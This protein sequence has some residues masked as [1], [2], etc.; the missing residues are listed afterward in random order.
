M[1]A[2]DNQVLAGR[3]V[4]VLTS[5]ERE[6]YQ[7]VISAM[8]SDNPKQELS[9]FDA[10]LP[11]TVINSVFDD[12][13]EEHPLL[14]KIRFA[15]AAALIKWLYSTMDDRFLAWW[16]PLCGRLK[17]SLR[18]NS[19]TSISNRPNCRL[20]CLLQGYVGSWPRMA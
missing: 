18:P 4:R 13:T 10:V 20:L 19:I 6:F 1:Q 7:K 3:G 5:N 2:S 11:E 15:N 8:K 9:G 16:G 14:S 17:P 12:I